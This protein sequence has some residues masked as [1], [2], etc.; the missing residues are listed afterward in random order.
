MDILTKLL[1]IEEIKCLKARYFRGVDTQDW[2]LMK[3]TFADD[4]VLDFRAATTLP[5]GTNLMP[6]ATVDLLRGASSAMQAIQAAVTGVS[7]VHHGHMP[8]IEI[9][10]DNNA[11]GIWAMADLMKFPAGAPVSELAGYG[12]YHETYCRVQG[13]WRINSLT[14]TRLRLGPP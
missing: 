5:D 7:T 1:A 2:V 3:D 9:V 8:E 4:I 13:Q 10:D 6:G 14:V 12:Y 11:R